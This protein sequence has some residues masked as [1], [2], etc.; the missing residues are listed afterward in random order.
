MNVFSKAAPPVTGRRK[1]RIVCGNSLE[2]PART[3]SQKISG[4]Q[5]FQ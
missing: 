1:N 3:R 2:V 4:D 5:D